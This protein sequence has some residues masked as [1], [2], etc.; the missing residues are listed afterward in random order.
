[1]SF[2]PEV[3]DK[4]TPNRFCPGIL[5][6][7]IFGTNVLYS[8]YHE[9][10]RHR[11]VINPAFKKGWNLSTFSLCVEELFQR[12]EDSKKLEDLDIDNLMQRV[13]VEALGIEIMGIKFDGILSTNQ[14]EFVKNF[15]YLM[16][17]A[18]TPAYFIFP[19][20]DNSWNPFR[21]D[22]YKK[23]NLVNEYFE[24]LINK[25]REVMK[26]D[27]D[28]DAKDVLSLLIESNLNDVNGLTNEEVKNNTLIFFLA[29]QDTTSFTLCATLHLLAEH[30]DIQDKLR[31]EVISVLG[32]EEY[33]N[34][35]FQVPTNEQLNK[36]ELTNAV[37]QESMRLYPA[38]T[39]LT[40]WI[41][42]KDYNHNGLKIPKNAVIDTYIYAINR[43]PKYFK[44]PNTFDPS[45]YLAGG[46]D[47]AKLES[48]W[49]SFSV[50]NRM[51]LGQSFSLVEQK[52]V[53][54]NLIRRYIVKPGGGRLPCGRELNVKAPFL[55]RTDNLRLD[56]ERALN[57]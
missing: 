42:K 45:R 37:I 10:K 41:C 39:I 20:L 57:S 54:S 15:N 50:G 56:F 49:F 18:L 26:K 29:G 36:L 32:K 53:L 44:N 7:K 30:P 55:L 22:A 13:T 19:K 23:L 33:I 46:I 16:R 31:Q 9:W 28:Y 17:A 27:Q 3:F 14:H 8:D 40:N 35:K 11:R 21:F 4:L 5:I 2:N 12:L 34:E 52:I 38:V 51:C 6:D 1:M 25:R 43:S 47:T 24:E 48:N